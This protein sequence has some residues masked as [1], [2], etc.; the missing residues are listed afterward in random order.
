MLERSTNSFKPTKTWYTDAD[1][2]WNEV[3]SSVDGMLG[4]LEMVHSPDVRDSGAFI[5]KLRSKLALNF[6]SK[7]ACDCG[8]G[9]GRVTKYFL[10]EQFD[11]V[12]LAEQNTK[13]LETAKASYLKK[14]IES[15]AVGDIFAVGLQEFDPPRGRYDTIWCQW[16]LNHLTN[17][18]MVAFLRRC[19]SGLAQDG[20]ICVK[21]N[22]SSKGYIVD[23]SDSSVT[24][25]AIIF[26]HI[27]KEAGLTV[28]AKQT[29]TDFPQGL[30]EVVMWAMLPKD[31]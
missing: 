4:G 16:V 3:P 8:A 11:K 9:I 7:Y 27:F 22:V 30:F 10:L 2:Y 19:A 21:E 28:V 15:G 26:E 1:K 29:Q 20:I 12:D 25:S 5:N 17:E 18:D 14:E 24:R 23:S 31:L 13:F 6:G